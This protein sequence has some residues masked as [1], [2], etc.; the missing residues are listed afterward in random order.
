[1][2]TCIWPSWCH[3]H[4]L[5]LASVKSRLVLPFWYWLMRVIPEKGPLNGCACVLN[6]NYYNQYNSAKVTE[7]IQN[8]MLPL[9]LRDSTD[10][11]SVAST[12][13][14]QQT[15]VL[16][17]LYRSTCIR[18]LSVQSFT[19]HMPLLTTTSAFGLGRRCWSSP[20]QCYL[21]S[22]CTSISSK[23]TEFILFAFSALTLLVGHQEEH[24]ACKKWAMRC[25]CGNLSGARCRLF[26]YGPADTTASQNPIIACLI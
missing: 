11:C 17:P 6:A 13:Y 22:L 1:M 12:V 8:I 7:P 19:A 26:A 14:I 10:L 3:C 23:H 21:R 5:S 18:I 2:Q 24:P 20:Q 15:T 9:S 25:W 4:S 16:W